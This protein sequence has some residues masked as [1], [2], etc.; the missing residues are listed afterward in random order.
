MKNRDMPASQELSMHQNRDGEYV[1][2]SEGGLTKREHFA[3]LSMQSIINNHELF[4]AITD[5]AMSFSGNKEKKV[6]MANT[7]VCRMAIQMA[8][9]LLEA[10]G[11]DNENN[12]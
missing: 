7:G 8:D 12:T 5:K 3:G 10:L 6:E 4:E 1:L 2:S 9:A 11:A